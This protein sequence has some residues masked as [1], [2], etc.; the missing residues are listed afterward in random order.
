MAASRPIY[1]CV[2]IYI[3]IYIYDSGCMFSGSQK[4]LVVD[5]YDG[6]WA[7]PKHDPPHP[8]PKLAT[9]PLLSMLF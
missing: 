6:L 9:T 8:P 5:D 4:N 7:N 3:Y 1:V 2:Y